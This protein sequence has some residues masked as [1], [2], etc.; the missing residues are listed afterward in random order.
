MDV[1]IAKTKDE[2][3]DHYSIRGNVFLMEQ[4]IS[5]DIEFDGLDKQCI[6]FNCYFNDKIVGAARLYKNKIGRVATL[7][8]YRNKGVATTLMKFIENYAK[9]QN[10]NTLVLNA[11][12]YVKDFYE[13]LGYTK[14]GSVFKEANIDHI[15]MIKN[16]K[17]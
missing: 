11:Q 14:E 13:H 10:I 1:K 4:N 5:W 12:L 15:R 7:R 17:K 6:L 16:I 2:I 3:I 9:S 8:D